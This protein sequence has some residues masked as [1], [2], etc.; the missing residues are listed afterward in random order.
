M[1]DKIIFLNNDDDEYYLALDNNA[2][3]SAFGLDAKILEYSKSRGIDIN[4]FLSYAHANLL[5]NASNEK[6]LKKIDALLSLLKRAYKKEIRFVITPTVLKE[7]FNN[8]ISFGPV[9]PN[10]FFHKLSVQHVAFDDYQQKLIDELVVDLMA[11]YETTQVHDGH[12]YKKTTYPFAGN[13]NQN[14]DHDARIFAESIFVGAD[15]FTFD[16]DFKNRDLIYQ[17]VKRFEQKHPETKGISKF[18][19]IIPLQPEKKKFGRKLGQTK[20]E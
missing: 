14:H 19:I 20:G 12:S 2:L 5:Y 9:K 18:K 7:V 1:E 10:L 6:Q 4:D 11:P 8:H 15:L 3:C 13:H 16:T 17:V